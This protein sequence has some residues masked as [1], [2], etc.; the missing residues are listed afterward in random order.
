VVFNVA[1]SC[2]LGALAAAKKKGVWGIG[3]D[4]DQSYLGSF[5]LTSVVKR[6]DVA[7]YGLVRS[8]T[9]GT[10]RTGGDVVFD[11]GNRGVGLGRISPKVPRAFLAALARIRARI[12]AGTIRVPVSFH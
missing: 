5:I 4:I 2:G 11:L 6:L 10:F 9:E 3:V 12:V 7:V 8:L 1:G